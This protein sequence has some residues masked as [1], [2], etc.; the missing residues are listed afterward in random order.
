M[1]GEQEIDKYTTVEQPQTLKAAS[2]MPFVFQGRI[3]GDLHRALRGKGQPP[4]TQQGQVKQFLVLMFLFFQMRHVLHIARKS[5]WSKLLQPGSWISKTLAA[6]VFFLFFSA[7]R[8]AGQEDPPAG[9]F[10][11]KAVE[12][13]RTSRGWDEMNRTLQKWGISGDQLKVCKV[14]YIYIIYNHIQF[15]NVNNF[16]V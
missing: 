1:N 2:L 16:I 15:E 14:K 6:Y 9:G 10:D 7:P 5:D 13:L 3:I 11:W 8:S 12:D 4:G